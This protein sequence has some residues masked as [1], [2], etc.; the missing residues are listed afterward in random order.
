[1]AEDAGE[2]GYGTILAYSD[3]ENGSYTDIAEMTDIGLPNIEANDVDKTTYTSPS[4]SREFTPGLI[5]PG[6]V[7]FRVLFD[8][9]ELDTLYALRRTTQWWRI[10]FPLAEGET[11]PSQWKGQGYLKKVQNMNPLDDKMEADMAV[12]ASGFWTF[13]PGS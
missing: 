11:V 2:I 6:E 4:Y 13:T 1:M 8:K 9:D 5:N 12:K 7:T 3:T 10:R